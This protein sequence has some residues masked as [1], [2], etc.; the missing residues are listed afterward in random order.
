MAEDAVP[1]VVAVV[2][3]VLREETSSMEEIRVAA[4]VDGAEGACSRC[5][6][7]RPRLVD[8]TDDDQ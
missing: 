3:R 8:M 5:E 1:T 6:S 2:V 4:T 7:Y